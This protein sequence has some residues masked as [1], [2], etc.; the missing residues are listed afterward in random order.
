[1][2]IISGTLKDGAGIP[3]AGCT[4]RLKAMNTT[5][6]VIRTTTAR[7][8]AD[9]GEYRIDALPARYEVALEPE[10][11]PPQKVGIIDVYTDSSDGSLNDF[12][13]AV[14]GDYLTPDVIRQFEPMVQKVRESAAAVGSSLQ[15]MAVI[16]TAAE[17]AAGD[18]ALSERNAAGA[19]LAAKGSETRA[20]DS[21]TKAGASER[22]AALYKQSGATHETN[23]AQSAADAALSATGAADSASGAGRSATEAAASAEEVKR[24]AL[25][26]RNAATAA[27]GAA[28]GAVPEVVR[29]VTAAVRADVSRAESAAA[30]AEISNAGAQKA[31]AAA[32][33]IAKTPGPEG[34]PAAIPPGN[35][36][37]IILGMY[38]NAQEIS[39][40]EDVEGRSI[41]NPYL[42]WSG[43]FDGQRIMMTGPDGGDGY[44]GVWTAMQPLPAYGIGLFIRKR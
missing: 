19:A 1:M 12:L 3:I 14:S 22:A 40:G 4:I 29:Q 15:R 21:A 16:K 39:A 9:A 7:V 5:S 27:S 23:A 30:S 17:K 10:G 35:V 13:T 28:A 26:A 37:S 11:S 20:A 25:D 33:L 44:T 43:R 6:A 38:S 32:Q 41:N 34:E 42:R 2:P 18:A 24:A 31:L 8:G 36:G